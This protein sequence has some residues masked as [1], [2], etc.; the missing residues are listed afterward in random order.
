MDVTHEKTMERLNKRFAELRESERNRSDDSPMTLQME[1]EFY[2]FSMEEKN[3]TIAFPVL[4]RHLNPAGAMMGG[5]TCTALD[6][7]YGLLV[8]ALNDEGY[9][10]PTV[11]MTTNFI[12]PIF[13]GD[14]LLITA[15]VE[16]WGK[17]IISMT[18]TG[19][20]KNTGKTI[21]T[22]TSAFVG[23]EAMKHQF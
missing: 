11:S 21:V 14:T 3:L 1:S 12:N 17:R 20:S 6:M 19:V 10:S 18:A 9:I 2:D 15:K 5:L 4:K 7:A 22:S 16:S 23:L 13:F 8:F